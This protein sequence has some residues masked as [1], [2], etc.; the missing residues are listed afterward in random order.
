MTDAQAAAEAAAPGL[1]EPGPHEEATGADPVE[2]PDAAATTGPAPDE[3]A[4]TTYATF[5]PVE[6]VSVAFELTDASPTIHLRE[7]EAPFRG[8]DFPIGLPEAQ[9]I[10]RALEG[11]PAP[12]PSTHDLLAT[13]LA[14]AGCDLVAVRITGVREGTIV[15]ELDLMGPRG[16]EVVDCRP[17]DGI[18]LALRVPARAP[19]LSD[20]ALLE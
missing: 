11:E 17:T 6:V 18:A 3:P 16:R 9:S 4:A 20:A 13:V 19:I 8:I 1:G 14:A 12:R 10:A 15:A 7:D 5:V 2:H